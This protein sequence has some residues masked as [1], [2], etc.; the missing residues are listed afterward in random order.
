MALQ[1]LYD[2]YFAGKVGIGT[3]S[4]GAKLQVGTRGTAA[5]TSIL[6]YDGIAFDFYNDG[7]PYKRHG[8]IISQAGDASELS[9]IH[10]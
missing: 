6:A 10:I 7:S 4:P 3:E 8:V 9:L 5:A 2:G 1:F